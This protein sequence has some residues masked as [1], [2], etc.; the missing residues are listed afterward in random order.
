MLV[1]ALLLLLGIFRIG[2]W[3][4]NELAERQPAYQESR[5]AAASNEIGKWPVYSRRP[6][7]EDWVLK[8]ESFPVAGAGPTV[9]AGASG[10]DRSIQCEEKAK[11]KE[12]QA[13]ANIRRAWELE[14][15]AAGL[16]NEAAQLEREAAALQEQ[17]D[18]YQG[19]YDKCIANCD[20]NSNYEQNCRKLCQPYLEQA[21]YYQEQA[22]E[23][24]RLADGK[25]RL[26][27]QKREEAARLRDDADGLFN[28]ALGIRKNCWGN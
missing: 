21:Q 24:R 9:T 11:A 7:T 1:A 14:Q 13:A 23:K 20:D 12:E 2:L 17:A 18:Y 4:H 3:Y 16:D 26:A 5:V 15:E 28:E 10:R 22:D 6:L 8:G 19:L 25:R 27:Q